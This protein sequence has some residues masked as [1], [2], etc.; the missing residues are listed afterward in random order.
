MPPASFSISTPDG[1]RAQPHEGHDRGDVAPLNQ[2]TG[3]RGAAGADHPAA[4]VEDRPFG[5]VDQ[6]DRGLQ[7]L[8]GQR[9][10][11]HGGRCIRPVGTG[12]PLQLHVLGHVDTLVRELARDERNAL[13]P[14]SVGAD[15]DARAI[16]A[17]QADK[18]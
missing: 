4:Q 9:F 6:V 14:E 13:K 1:Q 18:L 12:D 11:C 15:A 2:A 10:L 17:N 8:F 5:P 7:R 3:R 16:W